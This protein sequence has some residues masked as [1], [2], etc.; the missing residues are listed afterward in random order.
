MIRKG[1]GAEEICDLKQAAK[2]PIRVRLGDELAA[3]GGEVGL[4]NEDIALIDEARDKSP[5][6]PMTFE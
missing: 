4:T 6:K 5:A 3:L 2:S 1:R